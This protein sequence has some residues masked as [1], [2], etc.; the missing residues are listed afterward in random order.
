MKITSVFISWIAG[1]LDG[2]T[3][4]KD[5]FKSM[6]DFKF[7]PFLLLFLDKRQIDSKNI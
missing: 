2:F 5:F 1:D 6:K 3:D 7:F 4:L